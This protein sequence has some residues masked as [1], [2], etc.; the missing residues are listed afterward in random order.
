[1]SAWPWY[2]A[3]PA[4]LSLAL[5]AWYRHW[6]TAPAAGAAIVLGGLVAVV[7]GWAWVLPL[8]AAFVSCSLL[9]RWHRHRRGLARTAG[10]DLGQVVANG[11]VAA[12][13]AGLA[14]V[15]PPVV[16]DWTVLHAAAWSALA[17]DTWATE[18]GGLFGGQPRHLLTGEPL[19]CGTSGG[20][21]P[22][23]SLGGLVGAGLV[24]GSVW[25]AA[26]TVGATGFGLVV[27]CGVIGMLCDSLLGGS[28]QGRFVCRVCN[29]IVET[30]RHCQISATPLAGLP[31]VGN[32]LVNA[33]SIAVAVAVALCWQIS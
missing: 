11:G 26:P 21:T 6:L 9:T 10:R 23:G 3:W 20:V 25:W 28:L 16:V 31:F 12:L 32:D 2:A 5:L 22:I 33:T 1:M 4:A 14:W 18:I 19:D 7:G 15:A 13:V 30:R 17:A 24:A 29:T 27:V 8:L